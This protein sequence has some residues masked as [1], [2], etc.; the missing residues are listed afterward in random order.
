MDGA[1][2]IINPIFYSICLGNLSKGKRQNSFPLT[3][4]LSQKFTELSK[5]ASYLVNDFCRR[6]TKLTGPSAYT[7]HSNPIPQQMVQ[8]AFCD[9]GHIHFTIRLPMFPTMFLSSY[10][11]ESPL[12]C[13]YQLYK[14]FAFQTFVLYLIFKI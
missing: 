5:G 11:G 10:C 13:I 14:I 7:I 1:F 2:L 12:I 3:T 8:M 4:Y 6:F 9:L